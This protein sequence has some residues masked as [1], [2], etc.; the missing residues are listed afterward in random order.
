MMKNETAGV[1]KIMG[2]YLVTGLNPGI[3]PKN[4][5][6][7]V[8]EALRAYSNNIE[9]IRHGY[10]LYPR[11]INELSKLGCELG[12]DPPILPPLY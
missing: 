1:C 8:V 9:G 5:I 4:K 3:E 11:D 7:E 2:R 6:S 10:G 12:L